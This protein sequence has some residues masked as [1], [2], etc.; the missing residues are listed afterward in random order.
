MEYFQI[1]YELIRSDRKT[2]QIQV[3]VD[4]RVIVRA[5]RRMPKKDIDRFISDKHDWIVHA[6]EKTRIAREQLG[7]TEPLTYEEIDRLANEALEYI[8]KRVEHYASIMGVEYGNITIRNQKTRWGSCSGKKN[9]NFNCLLMLTDAKII[10]YVVVHELCHIKEMNHS[11]RF[12]AEVEK[13]LPDYKKSRAWL[14]ANG[15][16]IIGRN[17]K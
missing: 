3:K 4:G 12:W 16:A 5:P 17:L 15:S 11:Q 9:L 7:A 14:K 6:L 8:P 10:D 13:I 2:C 1:N